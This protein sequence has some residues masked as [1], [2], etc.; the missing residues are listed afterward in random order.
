MK[1]HFQIATW[2]LAACAVSASQAAV[3][4]SNNPRLYRSGNEWIQEVSGTF[5]AGKF[6]KVKSSS[7]SIR[8]QG[9]QQSN[10][11][12]TIREH[13][14]AEFRAQY[15][16]FHDLVGRPPSVVNSHHHIQVFAPIG[17]ILCEVLSRQQPRPY[18]RHV[19]ESL[20]D[21][22]KASR[23]KTSANTFSQWRR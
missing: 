9:A 21:G 1:R 17:K 16:R 19:R 3:A 2:I 23:R 4:Q 22:I 10:I 15:G 8:I 18:L 5:S 11:T 6:V 12:Y 7:G 13:V 20:G 14:R